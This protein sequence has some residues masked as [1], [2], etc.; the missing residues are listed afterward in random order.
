MFCSAQ[1]SLDYL[2][3]LKWESLLIPC[4]VEPWTKSRNVVKLH[5]I[6]FR[7]S[8]S[9]S[10]MAPVKKPAVVQDDLSLK[11]RILTTY[12]VHMAYIVL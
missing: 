1:F 7:Q 8:T 11:T 6:D 4:E 10:S 5:L 9:S 12:T 2:S 3:H